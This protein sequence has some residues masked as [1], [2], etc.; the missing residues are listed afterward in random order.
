MPAAR[1]ALPRDDAENAE[2]APTERSNPPAMKTSVPP[3]AMIPTGAAW[4]ARLFMFAAVRN[5]LL[6]S[7]SVMNSATNAST[8]P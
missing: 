8:M 1:K 2:I 5:T 6:V 7:E 3:Q 4:K